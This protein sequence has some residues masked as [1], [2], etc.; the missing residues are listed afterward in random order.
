M[1]TGI[2]GEFHLQSVAI[3]SEFSGARDVPGRDR[4]SLVA[5]RGE[6]CGGVCLVR[7]LA[8]RQNGLAL[9]HDG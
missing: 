8:G 5:A 6:Y 2:S 1:A 7:E 4:S 3:R 9:C